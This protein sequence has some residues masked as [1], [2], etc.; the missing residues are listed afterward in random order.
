MLTLLFV[1]RRVIKF[2]LSPSHT[3]TSST[4]PIDHDLV[5]KNQLTNKDRNWHWCDPIPTH[6]MNIH[7]RGLTPDNA[8]RI[9]CEPVVFIP[10]WMIQAL[11]SPLLA[12]SFSH[13]KRITS[14]LVKETH[15]SILFIKKFLR[16]KPKK[17]LSTSLSM[18]DIPQKQQ[19]KPP[20]TNV[21]IAII[22][23]QTQRCIITAAA[24]KAMAIF[25]PK[26]VWIDILLTIFNQFNPAKTITDCHCIAQLRMVQFSPLLLSLEIRAVS[27]ALSPV[28]ISRSPLALSSKLSNTQL[29]N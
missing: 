15:Y 19:T 26:W 27:Q 7:R 21:L 23:C 16:L 17:N 8:H 24:G 3:Y 10:C 29:T 20:T 25:F 2:H 28:S 11:K 5:V 14:S 4:T 13:G 22:G 12:Y 6:H 9:W 18:S 1:C